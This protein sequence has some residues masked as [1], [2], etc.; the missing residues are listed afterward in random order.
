M[1]RERTQW[2][3]KAGPTAA[4]AAGLL[5]AFLMLFLAWGTASAYQYG[6]GQ[7]HQ[8]RRNM[9]PQQM[10]DR[11]LEML[12]K[13]LNLTDEQKTKIKPVLEN[14]MK[15][16]QD[17]RQ[18]TSLTREDKRAKFLELRESTHKQI[19]SLLNADQQK[20]FDE[21]QQQMQQ[22][23]GNRQKRGGGN[24]PPPGGNR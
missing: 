17:I 2:R 10:M 1:T 19:R 13:R 4:I 21:W 20:S 24:P 6:G 7:R 16:M 14:E 8:G 22:R 11:H 23:R 18:N 15:Q 5:G 9:S 12:S 3:G